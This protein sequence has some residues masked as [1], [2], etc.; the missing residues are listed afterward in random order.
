MSKK[1]KIN[2][3]SII[4]AVIANLLV[5]GVLIVSANWQ[6]PLSTPPTCNSGDP[7]C[8]AP[9]NVGA[10]T[11]VKLGALGVSGIFQAWSDAFFS[12]N[13]SIGTTPGNCPAGYREV[14][15]GPGGVSYYSG[16]G[17]PAAGEYAL[18]D[19]PYRSANTPVCSSDS[20]AVEDF[21]S[22]KG[23]S[24]TCNV[25]STSR[26]STK[27][28]AATP[29]PASLLDVN[30]NLHLSGDL[31]KQEGAI[32]VTVDRFIYMGNY[33][34]QP[35]ATGCTWNRDDFCASSCQS[36]GFG[37]SYSSARSGGACGIFSC[38]CYG[39]VVRSQ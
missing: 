32:V 27:I 18:S 1:I 33:E 14:T 4:V 13:V 9:L 2:L 34:Y 39:A 26:M 24:G 16:S 25:V 37:G 10:S 5:A 8:D 28:I 17:C 19:N 6:A 7:G 35:D 23:T 20:R 15:G 38:R 11:Q 21:V 22:A 31:Q 29:Q 36:V 30:G 3:P 12:G